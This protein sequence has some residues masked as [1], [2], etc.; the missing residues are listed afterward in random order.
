MAS[1]GAREGRYRAPPLVEHDRAGRPLARPYPRQRGPVRA[2]VALAGVLAVG[3][4]AGR[5]AGVTALVAA[6]AVLAAAVLPRLLVATPHPTFLTLR[7][8]EAATLAPGA[9]IRLRG[10]WA[11]QVMNVH[12]AVP[13]VVGDATPPAARVRCSDGVT[14][15]LRPHDPVA[16]LQ[17]V[18]LRRPRRDPERVAPH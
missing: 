6:A 8:V 12:L 3:A 9:W 16:V 17:P 18:D 7:T 14:R 4:A 2:L 13:S 5:G 11:V 15:T 10:G 1:A